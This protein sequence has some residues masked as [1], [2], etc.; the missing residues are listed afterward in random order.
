MDDSSMRAGGGS[1]GY[2][3]SLG[4]ELRDDALANCGEDDSM[5]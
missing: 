1:A 3:Q 2:N 5:C 4:K